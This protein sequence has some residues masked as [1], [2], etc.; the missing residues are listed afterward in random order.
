MFMKN[1]I[2]TT[3]D[4][5]T[6]SLEQIHYSNS[7]LPYY[8][9]E[10]MGQTSYVRNLP[11]WHLDVEIMVMLED[12]VEMDVEGKKYLLTP[13]NGILINSS[14]LHNG[15]DIVSKYIC[16]RINPIMLCTNSYIEQNFVSP[17]ILPN[18]FD[19]IYL[20]KN[21]DWQKKI[22]DAAFKMNEAEVSKKKGKE[23][24]IEKYAF[25]IW[26]QIFTN[27]EDLSISE[28]EPSAKYTMLKVM[29]GYIEEHYGEHVTLKDIAKAASISIS[30]C[31]DVFQSQIHTSPINY[32]L[33]YRLYQAQKMLYMSN[34]SVAD[35]ANKCGFSS[36]SY[37]IDCFKKTYFITPK[38]FRSETRKNDW[39]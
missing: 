24:L 23:L 8:V 33:Q 34:D 9:R 36:A 19:A 2:Y 31:N 16:V 5:Y 29:I 13:G 25:E 4:I 15:K 35:I 10:V 37:F 26:Y 7:N 12:Q 28:K 32:L 18:S 39:K 3:D 20:D 1:N 22:I 11:H 38:K 30:S 27:S 21:V 17:V 14:R 6:D